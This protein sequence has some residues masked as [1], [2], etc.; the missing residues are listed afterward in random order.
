MLLKN[1][2]DYDIDMAQLG[3]V[4]AVFA[5]NFCLLVGGLYFLSKYLF[6]GKGYENILPLTGAVA[7]MGNFGI[8]LMDLC[9]GGVGVLVQ[10]VLLIANNLLL[11][12]LGMV[13]LSPGQNIIDRVKNILKLP[14]LPVFLFGV[15]LKI[16]DI[17]LPTGL[18]TGVRY[19]AGG[20][21]PVALFTLGAQLA[22]VKRLNLSAALGLSLFAKLLIAPLSMMALIALVNSTGLFAISPVLRNIMILGATTPTAVNVVIFATEFDSHPEMAAGTIFWG[23]LFSVVTVFLWMMILGVS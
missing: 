5:V 1:L 3:G 7:N 23:T 16:F 2:L 13:V 8:P 18:M 10:S 21:I 9:F 4:V 12:T 11:Y 17:S 20:L 15:L 6:K 14:F 19:M 22:S